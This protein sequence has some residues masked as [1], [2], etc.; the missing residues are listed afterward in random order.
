MSPRARGHGVRKVCRHGWRQ[1]PKCACAWYFSYKP[2]SGGPRYRFSLDVE[3]GRH[4]ES[5]TEAE[6]IATDIRSAI[7]AGTF[8]QTAGVAASPSVEAAATLLTLDQY[9]PIYIDRAAK[10]SGKASWK[11]D[12]YLLA[13]VRDH[14]TADGRRL[15]ESPLDLITEDELEAFHAAQRAAGRAVSTLN[16]LVQ[17]VKA[18]FRWAARKGYLAKSPITDDSALKRSKM[19][20]RRRRLLPA[21]EQTLLA[22]AGVRLQWLI[23]A[24]L[25]TGCRAGEL[26]ALQWADV[27]MDKR[28]VFVRAIKVG[29]KKTGRSRLLPMSARLAAV[30]EM[31]R[32]D[33]AGRG[34]PPTAY[35]FG[36]LGHRQGSIKKAWATAVL[37]SHGYMPEWIR[38]GKSNDLSH[39]SRAQLKTIDLHFHDLRHEAGCRWLEAG[40]PI[41]HVQEML[42]HANLSQTSTY[43]HAAEGGLQESMRR[44][45]DSARGK[46]VAKIDQ[47]EQRPFSHDESEADNKDRLH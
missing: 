45:D 21:E 5:K 10:A 39:Q 42:G 15:G 27:T 44:F 7:N 14:R 3:L 40:W 30:L 20:Q 32:V 38:K 46:P 4:V 13:T 36:E 9:A 24:A 35:V 37:K 28:T 34:Y 41:H 25:E 22:A 19:A 31:A 12:V 43:L 29:A 6:Q 18:A 16:H 33:P 2:R 11:D 17:I 1:W 8:R 23:I 47:V 26:L